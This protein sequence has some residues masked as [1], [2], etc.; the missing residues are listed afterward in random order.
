[1]HVREK[2]GV[3]VLK[4]LSMCAQVSRFLVASSLLLGRLMIEA[5]DAFCFF[6]RDQKHTGDGN[7]T[8]EALHLCVAVFLIQK[9]L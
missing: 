6:I 1:M 4:L 9:Q 3:L 5:Q 7:S 8:Q 2:Q